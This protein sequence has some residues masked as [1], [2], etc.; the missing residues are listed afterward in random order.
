MKRLRIPPLDNESNP[1]LWWP[2][3][4]RLVNAVLPR[5]SLSLSLWD[6]WPNWKQ[7]SDFTTAL[8]VSR[9]LPLWRPSA[10]DLDFLLLRSPSLSF[11]FPFSTLLRRADWRVSPQLAWATV[12]LV[13][14]VHFS[15]LSL[16]VCVCVDVGV[17]F[18]SSRF[19]DPPLLITES[20]RS[21]RLFHIQ[22]WC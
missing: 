5:T 6:V 4:Q 19:L 14:F 22:L 15:F 2:E 21:R 13:V 20:L 8:S 12:G 11:S 3:L 17:W 9:V 16:C 1:Q 10:L 7:S 18:K